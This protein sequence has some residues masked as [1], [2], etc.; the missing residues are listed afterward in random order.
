MIYLIFFLSVS[1]SLIIGNP[2]I[3]YL[4]N[5]KVKQS[6]RQE[7]P[8][9]HIVSKKDTPTLGGLIFLI[10]ICGISLGL[11]VFEKKFQT[12]DFFMINFVVISMALTGFIDD[13]LKVSNKSNKGL[14]GKL[15]LFIQL[16]ISI[17]LAFVYKEKS[18]LFIPWLFLVFAGSCNAYNLTDGLDGLVSTISL[19]SFLGLMVLAF[20]A[21]KIEIGIYAIVFLGSLSGFLFFNKY[22]AKIFMGDTGSLAIGAA[23]G[24]IAIILGQELYLI[25]F[26][27]IPIIE[28]ISVI[29]QVIYFK[30][31]KKIYGEGRRIFKMTPI[32][33]HFELSGLSEQKIVRV[34]FL[35]QCLFTMV[36]IVILM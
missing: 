5:L 24:G 12:F 3:G 21:N 9:E 10:P 7:G 32:H 22:P 16:L 33:H 34:F 8:K 1:L 26:S 31:T 29:L 19:V 4:R 36:G 15:R 6:F 14:S 17:L 30:A 35:V 13:F 28:T 20:I 2:I 25:F 11:F 27:I 23:V 18:L